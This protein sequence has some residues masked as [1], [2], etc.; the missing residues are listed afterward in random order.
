PGRYTRLALLLMMGV[1][2]GAFASTYSDTV[3]RSFRERALYAAGADLRASAPGGNS[4]TTG[5]AL[6]SSLATTPGGEHGSA[7]SRRT[8]GFAGSGQ[9]ANSITVLGVN[10][11]AVPG[12]IWYRPGLSSESLDGLMNDLGASSSRIGIPISGEPVSF[13]LWANPI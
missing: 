7:V 2:V 8:A 6:D 10:P 11:P 1:A 5:S 13:S 9:A 12:L 3:D 4:G